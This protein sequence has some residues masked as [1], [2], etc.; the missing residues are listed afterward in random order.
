LWSD[1]VSYDDIVAI[2]D[3]PGQWLSRRDIAV[4]LHVSKS[5]GLIAK[6]EQLAADGVLRKQEVVLLNRAVAFVYQKA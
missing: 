3:A 1:A 5:A 4:R 6:I 2:F